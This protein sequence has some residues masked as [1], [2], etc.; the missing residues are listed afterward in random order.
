MDFAHF[1]PTQDELVSPPPGPRP[2]VLNGGIQ[3]APFD[4]KGEG[5]G[6]AIILSC[7]YDSQRSHRDQVFV[8][9]A[10]GNA[11]KRPSV[12]VHNRCIRGGEE[13]REEGQQQQRRPSKDLA[14]YIHTYVYTRDL[15]T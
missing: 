9:A 14:C 13:G 2:S 12:V 8:I 1:A 7:D 3:R 15:L 10:F 6:I 4:K 5:G 11:G